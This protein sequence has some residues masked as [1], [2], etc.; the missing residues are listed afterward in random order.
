MLNITYIS[1]FPS[2]ISKRYILAGFQLVMVVSQ[3]GW[4]VTEHRIKMDDD[5]GYPYR[6]PADFHGPDPV[7]PSQERSHVED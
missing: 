3:N 2:S 1:T 6:N 5:W 7:G 4:F